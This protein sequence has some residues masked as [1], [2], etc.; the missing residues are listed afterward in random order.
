MK[1]LVVKFSP[2]SRYLPRLSPRYIPPPPDGAT[3]RGGPWRPLQYASRS[4]GSLLYLSIH[5]SPSFS[6]PWARHPA[7]SFLAFLF[8]LLH[9]ALR[10]ASF[11]G[12]AVSCTLSICPSHLILWH[13]I[14]LTMF[15]PLI[16]ASN[17]SFR[18]VPQHPICGDP[19]RMFCLQC[20]RPSSHTHSN[21]S[22][23]CALCFPIFV[24][25]DSRLP[26][27]VSVLNGSMWL[28][29]KA[30]KG[31]RCVAALIPNVDT[32]WR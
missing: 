20:R 18:Y 4:L 25:V 3:A 2:V 13:L 27:Q 14:N 29:R 11:F 5:L 23:N 31:S 17:S 8:V 6:G 12:T 16:M 30:Y 21:K 9:T 7:I 22:P 24:F 15:S 28:K 26:E 19:K 10:T 1:L 32:R